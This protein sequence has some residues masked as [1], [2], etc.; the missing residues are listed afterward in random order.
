MHNATTTTAT[1]IAKLLDAA[2]QAAMAKAGVHPLG[3]HITGFEQTAAG[4]ETIRIVGGSN[5]INVRAKKF[6]IAWLGR[7][8][9]ELHSVAKHETRGGERAWWS[10]YQATGKAD[11]I[12]RGI[13]WKRE[14]VAA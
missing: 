8:Y 12:I 10:Y 6:A 14:A 2:L 4:R 9:P 5:A 7:H 1:E 3:C 13:Y 11:S